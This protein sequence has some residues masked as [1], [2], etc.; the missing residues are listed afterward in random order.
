MARI[1]L[2]VVCNFPAIQLENMLYT[3]LLLKFVPRKI[4]KKNSE[5]NIIWQHLSSCSS[6]QKQTAFFFM[7]LKKTALRLH[8]LSGDQV[9][10]KMLLS[11]DCRPSI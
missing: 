5:K 7:E 4:T 2:A 1:N 11:F 9:T 3:N 8:T 10:L 6:V